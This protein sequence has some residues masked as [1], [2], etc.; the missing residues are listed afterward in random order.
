MKQSA[1]HYSINNH[2]SGVMETLVQAGADVNRRRMKDGWTPIFIAAVFGHEHKVQYL[3]DNKA[4]VLLCD[5]KGIQ[6]FIEN[7]LI[8]FFIRIE[9]CG[10]GWKISHQPCFED[11]KRSSQANHRSLWEEVC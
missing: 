10:L 5:D 1:L 9:S 7:V 8:I 6:S 2:S 11:V 4:D 3:V